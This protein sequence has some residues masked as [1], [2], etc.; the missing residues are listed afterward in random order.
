MGP[1][2]GPGAALAEA[3]T[4]YRERDGGTGVTTYARVTRT[5]WRDWLALTVS[6]P[7][8]RGTPGSTGIPSL[9]TRIEPGTRPRGTLRLDQP[10]D[11]ARGHSL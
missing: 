3:G 6:F 10:A 7:I 8:P 2:S 9:L 1:E 5:Y 4:W 11:M